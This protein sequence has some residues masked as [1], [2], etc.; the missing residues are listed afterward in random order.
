MP[1]RHWA[2]AVELALANLAQLGGGTVTFSN[3]DITLVAVEGTPQTTFDRVVGELEAALPEV[4]ALHAVLPKTPEQTGEGP[5]E[6]TATLSVGGEVQLRGRLDSEIT[7][8]TAD[9]YA[10]ARFGSEAVY[11]AA[12]VAEDLP[13]NWAV[14][15]LAG[16]EAL[17]MLANGSIA[18]TPDN[19]TVMG[20]TGNSDAGAEIA[21][22]LAQKLGETATF[23]I[24]VEYVKRLDPELGIPTP[25]DCEAQIVE[26]VG[27]RKLSFEPGSATLDSSAE[28]ILEDLSLLLKTCGAIPMEIGGHTDSQ[29]REVMNQ[30]LS[31]ERAQA[32]L[33]ALR[34][35]LVPV[36][37]YTVKGYG[38]EQPIAD[39][40]T[41][42][43][44]EANRRIEFKLIRA[45]L[46]EALQDETAED[47]AIR[48]AEAA[49]EAA[50][51]D[52]EGAE[53]EASD[54]D[55]AAP[56]TAEPSES[57][58]EPAAQDATTDTPEAE[59]NAPP[60]SDPDATKAAA[61]IGA[62]KAVPEEAVRAQ[63]FKP[64]GDDDS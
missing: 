45:A 28:T 47:I 49:P 10:R 25:E 16:L 7:R 13:L 22:L 58:A 44:R 15:A 31:Q 52:A 55:A 5:P 24:D 48:T 19:V 60:P 50:G 11:T 54:A 46:A 30:Q 37:H 64:D 6:F 29:G 18:V 27:T 56:K 8:Q 14:R 2:S 40:D 61:A 32:V 63:D 26:I 23:E 39:N 62:D 57:A 3:A 42:E 35:R 4:F 1:S 21:A 43:G 36:K 12:R 34:M 33:D 38:E 17:S 53:T 9:S 59:D 41:E 51:S 20:Q